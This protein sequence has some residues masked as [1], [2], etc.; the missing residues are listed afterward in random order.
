[1]KLG[2]RVRFIVSIRDCEDVK[3]PGL[4]KNISLESV[5]D[6]VAEGIFTV[7]LDWNITFFNQAAARIT[8]ISPEEAVGQDRK[9]VV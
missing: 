4:P 2:F 3:R 9:S 7:D 1:M 5:V 6:S 8:G